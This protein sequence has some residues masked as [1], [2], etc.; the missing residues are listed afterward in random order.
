[1]Y[2]L[3]QSYHKSLAL[4]ENNLRM[5]K[6]NQEK[7]QQCAINV[8]SIMGEEGQIKKEIKQLAY[9]LK[10]GFSTLLEDDLKIYKFWSVLFDFCKK[11]NS[12]Y[13]RKEL[14]PAE[15]LLIWEKLK[16]V[17]SI[18][19][20]IDK[21]SLP[22][23]DEE[24]A[25]EVRNLIK[26]REKLKNQKEFA[27]ADEIRNTLQEKGFIIEDTPYGQRVFYREK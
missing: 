27:R 14:T 17:V 20:M 7:I 25:G 21:S 22:I 2:L 6:K 15:A 19:K 13:F 26:K 4:S 5:W 12:L 3:S 18:L 1:M 9:D 23:R 8:I 10:K 11:V 16:D 24:L